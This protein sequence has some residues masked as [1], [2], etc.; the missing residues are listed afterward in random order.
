DHVWIPMIKEGAFFLVQRLDE[1]HVFW[2]Q[3]KIKNIK[4]FSHTFFSDRFWDSYYTTLDQPSKHHLCDRFLVFGTNGSQQFI[5]KKIV[6]PFCK[7]PPRF[8]LDVVFF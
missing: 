4:V 6:F 3:F 8:N 1:L 7:R 5:A 2:T